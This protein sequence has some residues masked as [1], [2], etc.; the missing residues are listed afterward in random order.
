MILAMG[1]PPYLEV[2]CFLQK[3]VMEDIVHEVAIKLSL[4]LNI[5]NPN[6]T[7]ARRVIQFCLEAENVQDFAKSTQGPT[8]LC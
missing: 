2:T 1:P 6:D 5:Q 7:L 8:C 4:A 3:R